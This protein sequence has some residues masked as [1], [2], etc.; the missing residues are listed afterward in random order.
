VTTLF[1]QVST[2]FYAG[3][4]SAPEPEERRPLWHGEFAE[5]GS[6]SRGK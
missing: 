2:I 3:R 5:T 4:A 1:F 6:A